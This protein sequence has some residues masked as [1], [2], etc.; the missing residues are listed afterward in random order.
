[1][2]DASGRC[3]RCGVDEAGEAIGEILQD[4]SGAT[5]FEGYTDAAASEQKI[6]RDVFARRRC[7]VSHRAI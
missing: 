4:A 3:V 1:M 2:R 5:R 6:L 7:L